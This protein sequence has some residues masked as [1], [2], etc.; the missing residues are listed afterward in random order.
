MLGR[1]RRPT[2]IGILTALVGVGVAVR[3]VGGAAQQQQGQAAPGGRGG[4]NNFANNFTGKIT[5]G[6][7][8]AMRMSRI[9]FEAGART[10][11]H[12]HSAGQLLRVEE[13]KG[14]VYEVGGNIVDLPMGKP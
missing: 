4:G 1:N 5:V 13:G 9:K 10:N 2:R 7:T 3:M 6:E 8:S 14:R 12:L 11:W